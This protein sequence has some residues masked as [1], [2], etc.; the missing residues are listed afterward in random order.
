MFTT[1]V[2]SL[3]VIL[4]IPCKKCIYFI[5]LHCIQLYYQYFRLQCQTVAPLTN[6]KL[7]RM[8]KEPTVVQFQ[9]LHQHLP[10]GSGEKHRIQQDSLWMRSEVGIS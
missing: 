7:E 5:Y 2:P 1:D 6:N 9:V 3:Y 4:C 10:G 8:W